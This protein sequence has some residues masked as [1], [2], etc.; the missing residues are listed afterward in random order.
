[1]RDAATEPADDSIEPQ[2]NAALETSRS[3]LVLQGRAEQELL[4]A[5]ERT[6]RELLAA[7]N[8]LHHLVCESPVIIYSLRIEGEALYLAS[9]SENVERLLGY[10]VEEAL[11][12]DWW[13]DRLHPE[14]REKVL[15]ELSTVLLQGHLVQEYRFRHGN[16]TYTWCRDE[17]RVLPASAGQPTE[18]VGSCSDISER[19]RLEGQLLQAQKMEA[20]GRLAGGVAHDFNNLLGVITGYSELLLK[21]LG[22]AHPGSKRVEEI[23]KAAERGAGLT[24]QLLAFSRQQVLQPRVLDLNEVVADVESM[25]RRVI[26]EDVELVVKPGAKLGRIRG[27]PGQIDQVLLNLVVNARDA[28]PKGGALSLETANVALDDAYGRLHPEVQP[29]PFVMLSVSDTGEGMDARTQTH[30]FEPFFTTK[31]AGKGTGLGLATVFGIVQQSGGSISVDSRPGVG[32]TVKICFPQVFEPLSRLDRPPPLSAPSS[33]A[34]TVL[35]VEDEGSLREMIREILE[36]ASYKVL[37]ASDP[38]EALS[39]IGTLDASV[40][41]MLTDVVMPGMSGPD[42]A[43]S[44]R[45]ARPEIKVLFMSGYTDEVMGFHGVLR[46]GTQ[47]IQKPFAADALLA[48][49]REA[50]DAP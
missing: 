2:R 13:S 35:L 14:E 5:N 31:E 47:F 11:A 23:Q 9:I 17:K 18:A 48:K 38:G 24:R 27:D 6:E 36:G 21:S 39:K 12:P 10:T 15:S 22:R 25:L 29:G 20:V 8:L 3:I 43:T 7:R 34:E 50:I 33:G 30:I 32:T 49:V 42:L 4:Q 46:S 1:M 41:L 28:M 44:V 40:C 19:K 37:E 45:A 16:G 26:G